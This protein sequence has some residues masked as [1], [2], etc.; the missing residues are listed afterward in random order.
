MSK[1][2]DLKIRAL[3]PG[4]DRAE[5]LDGNGLYLI[6]QPSGVKSFALRYRRAGHPVKLTLGRY[7]GGDPRDAPAPVVGGLLTLKGARKLASDALLEIANG[8]D[9][10]AAKAEAKAKAQETF[11][12]VAAEY[13]DKCGSKLRSGREQDLMLKRA[14]L[15]DLGSRPIAAI[16]RSDI[17]RLLEKIEKERGPISAVRALA[18]IRRIMNWHAPR[19]DDFNSPIVKGMAQTKPSERTR[20]RILSDD[21]LRAVWRTAGETPGP[22]GALIQFLLLTG[23]RRTEAAGMPWTEIVDGVWT[24]P[25]ARDKGK[26]GVTRPLSRAALAVLDARPRISDFVFTF[27]RCAIANY[28]KPKTRFDE[29]CGVTDWTLHDLRRT[30]RSLM[31]RAGVPS[32][33]AERCLG[34]AIGGVEGIYN[35]HQYQDEMLKAY[36]RLASQ[37]IEIVEPPPENVVQ[38]RREGVE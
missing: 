30:A 16:R 9:P 33:H 12:M 14:V 34:H 8:G 11:E 15:P 26:R 1:L 24:L 18:S 29:A 38:L 2:T 13:M 7:F 19:S 35:R 23:A 37:I 21:E 20:S 32:E 31:S 17:V 36:E 25:A 27:G 22:F 3:K 6:V 10:G 28:S 5:I 4:P